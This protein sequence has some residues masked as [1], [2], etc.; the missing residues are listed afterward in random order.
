MGWYTEEEL[1]GLMLWRALEALAD[2]ASAGQRQYV[3]H[4][5][6]VGEDRLMMRSE[7]CVSE[8]V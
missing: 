7:V 3:G 8:V 5:V 1:A 6:V 2:L 4:V